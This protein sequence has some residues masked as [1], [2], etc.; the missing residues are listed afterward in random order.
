VFSLVSSLSSTDSAGNGTL[1]LF[2][3]F[4]GTME[5][6]A[7]PATYLSGLWPR[8]FSDRSA[9]MDETDVVGVSRLP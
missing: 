9:S 5:L 7:S 8:A 2:A 3:G 4:P 6:P 1:P